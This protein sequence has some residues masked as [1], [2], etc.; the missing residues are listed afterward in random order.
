MTTTFQEKLQFVEE[1]IGR[2][3][4]GQRR[5]IE[6][7]NNKLVAAVGGTR[8]CAVQKDAAE[9]PAEVAADNIEALLNHTTRAR[10]FAHYLDAIRMNRESGTSDEGIFQHLDAHVSRELMSAAG[11]LS[12]QS[13][14]WAVNAERAANLTALSDI[15]RLFLD[16]RNS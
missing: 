10:R 11:Y 16:I 13:T 5:R 9:S 1:E 14:S 6:D 2:L 12:S 3:Y 4:E 7:I 15:A 8:F